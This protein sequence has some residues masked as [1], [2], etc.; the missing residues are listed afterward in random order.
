M[1]KDQKDLVVLFAWDSG[2]LS[3]GLLMGVQWNRI[4]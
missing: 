3:E 1:F 2:W 4:E